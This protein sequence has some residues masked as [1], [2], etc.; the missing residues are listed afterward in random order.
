[1]S[2]S[3]TNPAF[4]VLPFIEKFQSINGKKYLCC[5]SDTPVD[6]ENILTIQKNIFNGI[7]IPECKNCYHLESNK[8]ISP[9][10]QETTRWLRDL[11][12]KEYLTNWTP[13]SELKT[14]Y[15]DVRYD[16]KC[17]LACISCNP[18][19]SSL[20]AKEL[21]IDPIKYKIDFKLDEL[22]S[23]KK[24]YMAGGEPLIIDSFILLINHIAKLDQQP[25][26]VINTNL[27]SVTD[28]LKK[29]LSKIK[30][31]TL[32]VSIDAYESV[33]EYHRWPMRWSKLFNNLL[34]IRENV[35]CTIQIN[36]VI[37]AVTILNVDQLINIEQLFDQWTLSIL[38]S[39]TSLLV[40][41]L[42]EHL[43]KSVA[44]NFNNIKKSKFYI[45]DP[46][47]K[48][49]IDYVLTEIYKPGHSEMLSMFIEQLDQRRN[50]NHETY[51]GIKLT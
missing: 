40:Q 49:K 36:S 8:V 6:N 17:N 29:S 3:L 15:Y 32:T 20:W 50:I 10:E 31:L 24:I 42:P 7:K 21:N 22:A 18:I 25:E 14:F 9:R 39:P 28:K 34:W 4:C 2:I 51:L 46:V 19:A 47:F 41:N 33:N 26:L 30:N 13:E 43:K 38:T 12:V 1:M 16:N 44:D 35:Q 27:T 23:A 5:N 48:T 45:T 37:D 11:E